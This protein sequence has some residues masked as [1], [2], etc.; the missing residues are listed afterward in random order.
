M[1]LRLCVCV[2]IRVYMHRQA[3]FSKMH[4]MRAR[5]KENI[6]KCMHVRTEHRDI[7]RAPLK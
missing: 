2:R 5:V 6:S 1:P 7:Q 4:N 3:R